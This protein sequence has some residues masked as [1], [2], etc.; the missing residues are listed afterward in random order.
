MGSE[1]ERY[2]V[3]IK[4][5]CILEYKYMWF[6]CILVRKKYAAEAF[7]KLYSF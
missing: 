3:E 7:Q 5:T 2:P 4:T 1:T 6:F